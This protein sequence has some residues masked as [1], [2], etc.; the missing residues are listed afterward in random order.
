VDDRDP[1]ATAGEEEAMAVG[2]YSF[3]E[4]PKKFLG[5]A[6]VGGLG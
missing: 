5:K 4:V 6:I 2:T 3:E 1:D